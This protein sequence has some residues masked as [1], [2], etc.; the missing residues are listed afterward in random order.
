MH[1]DYF[2]EFGVDLSSWGRWMG[3]FAEL[4]CVWLCFSL[5]EGDFEGSNDEVELID[6]KLGIFLGFFHNYK[7]IMQKI[8]RFELYG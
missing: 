2:T 5:L 6:A 1:P 8:Y 3:T 4:E 7:N